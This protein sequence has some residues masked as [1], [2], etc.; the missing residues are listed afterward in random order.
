MLRDL[1]RQAY[2]A[3]VYNR[4]RTIDHHGRDGVGYCH[5][6]AAAGLRAGIRAGDRG[7]LRAVGHA[8][9]RRLSGDAPVE[10]AG[11]TKAGVQVRF[12]QDDIDR[13]WK[14]VPES[15]HI[16]PM[17]SQGC[18]GAERAAHLYLDGQRLSPGSSRRFWSCDVAYRALLLPTG[19]SR[20]QPCRRDWVGGEDEA[21][22]GDVS[23]RPAHPLEWH[24]LRRLSAC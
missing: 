7:D 22:S 3:M 11:G 6:R 20:A 2:E 18:S 15:K 5:G 17:L 12:T 4:R 19:R 1:W 9:D 24:Q 10:Q 16:A 23:D 14:T 8:T 21:V 13:L